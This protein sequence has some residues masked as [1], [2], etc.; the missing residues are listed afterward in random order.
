MKN[1]S[2][3]LASALLLAA[4]L[5]LTGCDDE[6]GIVT[7]RSG[8]A[9]VVIDSGLRVDVAGWGG[10]VITISD[11]LEDDAVQ[12]ALPGQRTMVGHGFIWIPGGV[13]TTQTVFTF[14]ISG[15]YQNGDTLDLY[16]YDVANVRWI[17]FAGVQGVVDD[18]FCVVTLAN[19]GTGLGGNF[20]IADTG[21]GGTA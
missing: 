19:G 4:I 10:G 5:M 14:P 16:W 6:N 8:N 21:Q 17:P 13:T 3:V 12:V 7:V 11:T 15:T 9:S 18:G 1:I 2:V 20:A